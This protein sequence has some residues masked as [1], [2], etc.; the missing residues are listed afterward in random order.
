MN[1][2]SCTNFQGHRYDIMELVVTHFV[3][4]DED[5][6]STTVDALRDDLSEACHWD[7]LN[8]DTHIDQV[9]GDAGSLLDQVYAEY[10][11]AKNVADGVEQ[12]SDVPVSCY[13][14]IE[15]KAEASFQ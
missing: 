2:T 5:P 3:G 9:L 6:R 7:A 4:L 12:C 10:C 14:E 15:A 13:Q 8:N 1:H 11:R